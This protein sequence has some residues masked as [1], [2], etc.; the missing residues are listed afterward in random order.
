MLNNNTFN[1]MWSIQRGSFIWKVLVK[2]FQFKGFVHC[3]AVTSQKAILLVVVVY[4]KS[5][6]ALERLTRPLEYN[7]LGLP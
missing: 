3:L 1:Y 6:T 2:A 7:T 4:Y 5:K